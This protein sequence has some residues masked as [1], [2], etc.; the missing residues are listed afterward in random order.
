MNQ[1]LYDN[2]LKEL[3]KTIPLLDEFDLDCSDK[4]LEELRYF[5]SI[6]NLAISCFKVVDLNANKKIL[7]KTYKNY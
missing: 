4:I 3:Q 2:I 6:I 7:L 5:K 1:E